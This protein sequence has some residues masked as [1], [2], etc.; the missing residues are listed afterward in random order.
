[1]MALLKS[2]L[3]IF[4]VVF[5]RFR[6]VPRLWCVWLVAVNMACLAFIQHVEAQAVLA[7]T[8][9]A[10]VAQALI[11]RKLGFTRLLGITH[12]LWVPMF[13]WIATRLDKIAMHDDLQT[14]LIVL[15]VTNCVSLVVDGL[16]V[17]RFLA[18]E[19]APYY[20]WSK[21]TAVV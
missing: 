19:R 1:M 18:G 8:S 14:W 6:I 10:L 5:L 20:H 11:H 15:F 9:M 3:E 2:V 13:A 4:G 7:C 16:D 21:P 17:R 12:A